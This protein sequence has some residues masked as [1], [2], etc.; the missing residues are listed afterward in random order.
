MITLQ[1]GYTCRL[2]GRDRVIEI[3]E[4]AADEDIETFLDHVV[5]MCGED[6]RRFAPSCRADRVDVK[7]P[8]S[9]NGIGFAG[10]PLTEEERKKLEALTNGGESNPPPLPPQHGR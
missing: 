3:R 6:H 9:S 8:V 7:I 1:G 2:C 4:R 5:R 10:E